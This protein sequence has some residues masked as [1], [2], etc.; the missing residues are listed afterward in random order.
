MVTVNGERL[1]L[2][3][4]DAVIEVG[5][6]TSERDAEG[7]GAN[8]VD[9]L[10]A[11]ARAIESLAAA[12]R[13]QARATDRIAAVEMTRYRGEIAG[14]ASSLVPPVL[15]PRQRETAPGGRR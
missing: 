9:G 10:F 7:N 5:F 3:A 13:E 1:E 12:T 4:A 14:T 15:G 6:S 11:I 2:T 8:L